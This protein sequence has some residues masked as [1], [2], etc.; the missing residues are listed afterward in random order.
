MGC[1]YFEKKKYSQAIEYLESAVKMSSYN[2]EAYYY[3]GLSYDKIGEK[4]K[5]RECLSRV[6]EL[7]PQS[8]F[9]QEAEKKL[10]KINK[11]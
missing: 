3:L 4:E 10:K 7:A 2:A 9:A 6:I 8:E 5:A 1:I 11:D